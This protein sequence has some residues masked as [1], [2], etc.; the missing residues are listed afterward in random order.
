MLI[1]IRAVFLPF[2]SINYVTVKLPA[3]DVIK[4]TPP[5]NPMRYGF[6][7]SKFKSVIQFY[8][9]ASSFQSIS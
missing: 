6:S 8:N 2:L 4:P 1:R 7:H 5:T 3:A 9:D